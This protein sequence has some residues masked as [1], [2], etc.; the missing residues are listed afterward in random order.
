MRGDAVRLRR[1]SPTCSTTR[2]GTPNRAAASSR[3]ERRRRR[4]P[5]S[6]RDNGIGMP[7]DALEQIFEPFASSRRT[8]ARA[9]RP[10]HRPH[11]R[12]AAGGAAR[13][14]RRG[15]QRGPGPGDRDHRAPARAARGLPGAPPAAPVAEE[16]GRR[17]CASSPST[18][19]SHGP[20]PGERPPHVGTHRPHR[21]RRRRR[22]RARRAVRA[23]GRAAGPGLAAGRRA[24]GGAAAA[25]DAGAPAGADGVDVG[26]RAGGDAPP[27]RRGGLPPP[28]RQA[29]RHGRPAARCL[30][31]CC[32]ANQGP[33]TFP[34]RG[35]GNRHYL[36]DPPG[37]PPPP[38]L[39]SRAAGVNCR[40]GGPGRLTAERRRSRELPLRR[41]RPRQ[42]R[43]SRRH[44]RLGVQAHHQNRRGGRRRRTRAGYRAPSSGSDRSSST[45]SQVAPRSRQRPAPARLPEVPRRARE[46]RPHRGAPRRCRPRSGPASW[47]RRTVGTATV[48]WCR[49]PARPG[50]APRPRPP[51]RA[52]ES[53]P[54]PGTWDGPAPRR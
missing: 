13:R 22:P 19:T 32:A 33:S 21:A 44:I 37:Q 29:V 5:L 47:P 31:D 1:S 18:T 2:P 15:A 49:P 25:P 26:F 41:S 30:D 12:A 14:Q 50:T 40:S 48:T 4:G 45:R 34:I 9:G 42:R 52:P 8:R 35:D 23:R 46:H 27:Q 43:A 7:A 38:R 17:R 3:L 6:V 10:G 16:T 39:P 11:A 36:R 28:P 51:G 53:R 20:G 24:G 54:S